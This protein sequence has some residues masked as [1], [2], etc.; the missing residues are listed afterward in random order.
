MARAGGRPTSSVRVTP[1]CSLEMLPS[2]AMAVV[3]GGGRKSQS[4]VMGAVNLRFGSSGHL[5]LVQTKSLGPEQFA[6]LLATVTQLTPS[7][8]TEVAGN[9]NQELRTPEKS[10]H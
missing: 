1:S 8:V 2:G 6:S 4:M 9:P 5:G 7:S 10:H 3:F